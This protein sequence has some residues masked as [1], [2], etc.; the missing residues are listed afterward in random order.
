MTA[1][2][3]LVGY[4]AEERQLALSRFQKLQPFLDGQ[5]TLQQV[6]QEHNLSYSTAQRWVRQYR[7]QGLAGLARKPRSDQ[8]TFRIQA[9]LVPVIEGL[10]LR[11]PPPSLA[12]IHRQV[13]QIASGQGWPAPTYATVRNVVQRIDKGLLTLAQQGTKAYSD[14]FDLLYARQA[15]TPNEIWQADHALLKIYL[16]NE[17]NLPARPWL[18]IILD[19]Y[20]R[21]IA[22]YALSF[23]APTAFHTALA[24]RQAI[25]RKEHPRWLVCGIPQLFYTDHGSDF[26][27]RHLEQVSADL[28]MQLVFSTVG[29]PRGRGRIERFFLTVRQLLV[30]ELPGYAPNGDLCDTPQLTLDAFDERLRHFIIETYHERIHSTT[31]RQPQ[32]MWQ[33]RGFVPRLPESLEQL[34]LLLLTVPQ[35]RKVRQEGIRFKNFWYFDLTLSAYVGEEVIIRYDPRDVA[36]IRVYLDQA[37]LC[38]AICHELAGTTVSLKEILRQRNARRRELKQALKTRQAVVETYREQ[39]NESGSATEASETPHQTGRLKRYRHD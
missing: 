2:S 11:K 36:E 4:S 27:S 34:D 7:E 29:I 8:G 33:D 22:G 12:S 18:T 26:T 15:T 17:Q 38:R 21:A 30:S 5:C 14:A 16:L 35:T 6:A 9:E 13:E 31:K 28:K 3:P 10:A 25:W 37:F 19:D 23:E 32:V 1:V 20:S 39:R 24:L